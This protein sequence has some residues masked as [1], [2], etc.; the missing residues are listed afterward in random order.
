MRTIEG[1][2]FTFHYDE[3]VYDVKVENL[4]DLLVLVLR[5][6]QNERAVPGAPRSI[7]PPL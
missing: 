4:F 1:K 6:Y 5:I 2:H 3:T 7:S